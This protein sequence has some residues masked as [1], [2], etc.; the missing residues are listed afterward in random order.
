[1][2]EKEMKKRRV[3]IVDDEMNIGILIQKLI[4]WKELVG[5]RLPDQAFFLSEWARP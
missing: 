5:V 4:H 2:S 3:L 1:M